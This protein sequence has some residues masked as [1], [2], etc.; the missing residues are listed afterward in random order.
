MTQVR[1]KKKAGRK[2]MAYSCSVNMQ[3]K[4]T[5]EINTQWFH[6]RFQALKICRELNILDEEFFIVGKNQERNKNDYG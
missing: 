4:K 6:E 2:K 1:V 3:E 5:N